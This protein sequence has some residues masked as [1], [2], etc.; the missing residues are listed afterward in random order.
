MERNKLDE[1][2]DEVLS[3]L[4]LDETKLLEW[5]FIH[6]KYDAKE[7]IKKILN[8]PPT[9][10]IKN[11]WDMLEPEGITVED[12]INNLENRFL[13]FSNKGGYRSRY[14]ETYRLLSQLKQ[15]FDYDDWKTAPDLV[16]NI[17]P[18]LRYRKFPKRN[19]GWDE[20]KKSLQKENLDNNI[21]LK[22]IYKLINDGSMK[23]SNF[24]VKSLFN[25]LNKSKHKNG[26]TTATVIG[27]GTG[28]GKTLAFYLPAITEIANDIIIEPKNRTRIISTYPRTE[29]LKDQINETLT[30]IRKLNDIMIQNKGRPITIGA[31]YGDTPY[32]ADNVV[33][34]KYYKWEIYDDNHSQ[35]Y[36]CPYFNCP[37]CSQDLIW[38]KEDN[39]QASNTSKSIIFENLYCPKCDFKVTYDNIMLTR[40]R[41]RETPPD[42][43]FTTTEMLNRTIFNSS[44]N[45]I[46]GK[47]NEPPSYFLLDEAH[48]Y[49]GLNGAQ[50][51]YLLR[52]WKNITMKNSNS[53]IHFVGLSA[54]LT[55]AKS[56]FSKLTGVPEK[57]TE[58]ITPS[59]EELV[60]KGMEYNLVLRGDPVSKTTLLSTTVQSAMLLSRMLD[61]I[62]KDISKGSW[63]K[64]IFGF[65]DKL[66]VTNRWHF[67]QLDAEHRLTLSQ[68]RDINEIKNN[69]NADNDEL[70]SIIAS[71]QA[72]NIAK[73][74]ERKSLKNPIN[75]EKTSSQSK[76]VD[77]EA[78]LVITTSTLE[79]GYDDPE[80]G[81]II[82]HKSPHNLASFLQRKGRGGRPQEMRP[83]TVVITSAYGRDR[84]FYENPD[85]LFNPELP[86][87]NLPINNTYVQKIHASFGLMDWLT[88]KLEN[89]GHK[90]VNIWNILNPRKNNNKEIYNDIINLLEKIIYKKSSDFQEFIMESLQ[91]NEKKI[92]E[93]LWL[94]PR[95]I[96][97]DLIPN[98]II[99]LREVW[100]TKVENNQ[101]VRRNEYELNNAPLSNYITNNL[102]T[103]IEASEIEIEIPQYDKREYM[104]LRQGLF[105]F[106]PGNA[107]KRY[108]SSKYGTSNAHWIPV[109]S[110]KEYIEVNQNNILTRKFGNINHQD[111]E[112]SLF[113]P[114]CLKVSELPDHLSDR[115]RG[116]LI[117][118]F[119]IRP[120]DKDEIDNEDGYN[121]SL[122]ENYKI[123]NII[124]N[125]K[126]F[127]HSNN[128][129]INIIRYSQEALVKL[130]LK[131]AGDKE[132]KLY[133]F[134]KNNNKIAIGF[135]KNVDGLVIECNIPDLRK[136][137]E[138]DKWHDIIANSKREFYLHILQSEKLLNDQLSK[139]DIE[140]LWEIVTSAIIG[141]SVSKNISIKE[142]IS[143]YKNNHVKISKRVLEAIFRVSLEGNENKKTKQEQLLNNLKNEEIFGVLIKRS[144]I[145]YENLLDRND[146]WDWLRKRY[147]ST[148]ASAFDKAIQDLLPDLNTD[149]LNID[150]IDNNIWFTEP[151]SGGIG[152]VSGISSAITIRP[153]NF[154]ELFNQAIEFCPRDNISKQL[155]NLI[156]N[157]DKFNKIFTQVRKSVNLE[158]QKKSLNNL[159]KKLFD[160]GINP[161]KSIVVA[162]MSKIL[163]NNSSSK[164]DD[165]IYDLIKS[166]G[167]QERR[168]GLNLDN[169]I[170]SVVSLQLDKYQKRVNNI[171]SDISNGRDERID[172]KQRFS[173]VENL[174]WSSC[175]DSCPE[176][177]S[178]YNPYHNLPDPARMLLESYIKENVKSIEYKK[179][180]QIEASMELK[181][182]NIFE[183]ECKKNEINQCRKEV[184]NFILSPIEIDYELFYP[185]I[186]EII[187]YL[188]KCKIKI[189]IREVLHD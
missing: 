98:L 160:F 105:E 18:R 102:F 76:G 173:L 142:S 127:S 23:L 33:N 47:N 2:S 126:V 79:V 183:L 167:D 176:C 42:I 59:D 17:K 171:L 94:P 43:L 178:I 99:K 11:Y 81:A 41:M 80:I 136:L 117:W 84:W 140:W 16:S 83:W 100:G 106:A 122:P 46:F 73:I 74:I 139:F 170:F 115:S 137:V 179:D 132:K 15:R 75:L 119:K 5:G 151:D 93:I 113:E 29:L 22:I 120:N 61:P 162:I 107:T 181:K 70:K 55:K 103:T 166:R 36:V 134:K 91:V 89:H 156:K 67:I 7:K 158:E 150:I 32:N 185:K 48:I 82:Q 145:L 152:L 30:N 40:N 169:R 164:T 62:N 172:S 95:S 174:L 111:E 129:W 54:T 153:R 57:S 28:S 27:A 56:F 4:E 6:I 116:E 50:V 159:M 1:L 71:G 123:S 12:I 63:G 124:K 138:T 112:L 175:K 26:K 130:K 34:N 97:I 64:K 96:M 51:S 14:A 52:R 77:K 45:H 31:Y 141:I 35:G 121:I 88:M 24:Q 53:S 20:I 8:S 104:P 131:K 128:D 146:F 187:F 44:Y 110:S 87:L 157:K 180:W 3:Q 85:Y 168:I 49:S 143:Y 21:N 114:Y 72:W 188:D 108:S 37:H 58:Y 90:Q 60:N 189:G 39:K 133:K 163:H 144:K 68:F 161:Q 19:I 109:N 149:D 69:L 184:L 125:I 65:T 10:M 38:K 165:L 66:D 155:N 92:K 78:K 9:P 148:V 154:I 101:R 182:E 118:N 13:L 135:N 25:I 186:E 86:I 147:V 177:L